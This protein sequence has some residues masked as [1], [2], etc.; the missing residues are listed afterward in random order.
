[1][2]IHRKEHLRIAETKMIEQEMVCDSMGHLHLKKMAH[3]K[4]NIISILPI[5]IHNIVILDKLIYGTI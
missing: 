1:M 3:N 4:D 5:D 2:T